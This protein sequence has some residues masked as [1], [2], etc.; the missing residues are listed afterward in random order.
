MNWIQRLLLKFASWY[1][2]KY[3]A[4]NVDFDTKIVFGNTIYNI[5]DIEAR[6]T[7][8]EVDSLKISAHGFYSNLNKRG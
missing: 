8:G 7:I 2:C 3:K 4:I 1:I 6:S 5:V